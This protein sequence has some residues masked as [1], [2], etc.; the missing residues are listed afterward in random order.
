MEMVVIQTANSNVAMESLKAM[1]SAMTGMI[2]QL[3]NAITPANSLVGIE[4]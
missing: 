1:K 3:M 4:K 2:L